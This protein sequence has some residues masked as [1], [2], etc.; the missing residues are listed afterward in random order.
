MSQASTAGGDGE[1]TSVDHLT[2]V[3][4]GTNWAVNAIGVIK[5]YIHDDN[6]AEVRGRF[7][8]MRSFL[9]GARAASG[10]G[11]V[12]FKLPPI[13]VFG[14]QRRLFE[15]DEHDPRD[16]YGKTKSLGE[17]QAPSLNHLRC[18]IIG[19]ELKGHASLLDWFTRQ[20]A[21]A[22]VNGFRNHLWNGVTTLHFGRLCSGIIRRNLAL[23]ALHHVVP[24]DVVD[25]ATLL[26][27]F[28]TA[29]R[30]ADVSIVPKDAAVAVD[31]TPKTA[32]EAPIESRLAA[33]I[34]ARPLPSWR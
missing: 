8:S 16:V 25:K 21:S 3:R 24:D 32:N 7:A 23:P 19:P 9:R 28:R 31:R 17:V 26:G 5:P 13:A 12:S 14:R 22:T 1:T 20:P 30:R 15:A 34:R 2:G 18:S 11:L 10:I 29:F 6:R 4:R 27:Q 33:A